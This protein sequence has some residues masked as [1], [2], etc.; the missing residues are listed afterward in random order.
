MI[1]RKR[2][3]RDTWD[4]HLQEKESGNYY[5]LTTKI[6]LEDDEARLAI[7]VDRAQGGSSLEDGSLEI[8]IHRRLLHDDAFGV[9]EALN[10]TAYGKG[11]I[12]RGHHYL[13][14]GPKNLKS[15]TIAAQERFLQIKKLLPS[16]I[17]ISS[18]NHTFDEWKQNYNHIVSYILITLYIFNIFLTIYLT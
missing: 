18:T 8:M 2:N 12:A 9:E 1:R 5:P 15:P 17:F 10:E 11:L 7:L 13:Y 16:W 3:Q 4:L 6:A 14:L